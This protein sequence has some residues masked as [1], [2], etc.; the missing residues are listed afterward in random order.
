MNQADFIYNKKVIPA[1]VSRIG[2]IL[3]AVGLVFGIVA[4]FTDQSRAS[5]NYLVAYAFMISIGVGSLFLIA[6]EYIVGAVW[7]VPIRRIV[8]FFA[9]TVPVLAILVIP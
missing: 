9:A 7:S 5:Y 1:K 4:F 6:L 8:E 2:M 3:F